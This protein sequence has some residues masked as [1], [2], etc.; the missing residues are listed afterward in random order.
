MQEG[1]FHSGEYVLN[2]FLGFRDLRGLHLARRAARVPP[3]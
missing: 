3:A 1:G 2:A